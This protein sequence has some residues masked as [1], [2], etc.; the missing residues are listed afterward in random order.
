MTP[1][2]PY[3]FAVLLIGF[4]VTLAL[5]A[6]P[7]A[8]LEPLRKSKFVRAMAAWMP[9]GILGILAITTFIS[10][11]GPAGSTLWQALVAA[12]V[13]IGVHLGF[14]RHALASVGAGTLTYVLLLNL[15]PV[16]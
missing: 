13:T 3:I 2:T 4:A 15:V 6:V 11:A 8:V 12:A 9:P 10:A 14:G 1:S 16:L 5:R 7:F